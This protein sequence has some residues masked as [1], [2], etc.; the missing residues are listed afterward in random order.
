M[1][2][3]YR[4]AAPDDIVFNLDVAIDIMFIDGIPII[5]A[6]CKQTHLSRAAILRA[7][8]GMI[9][10]ETFMKMW[11]CPYLGAPDNLWVDQAKQ[12]TYGIFVMLSN[13]LG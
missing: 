5:H 12:F 1:P 6:V 9:I 4:S 3:R 10:W 11:A 2:Q 8:D 13:A 7:Q